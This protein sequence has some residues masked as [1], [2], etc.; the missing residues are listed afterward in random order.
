MCFD[1]LPAFMKYPQNPEEGIGF[2]GTRVIN[3]ADPPQGC[4]ASNPGSLEEQ[5]LKTLIFETSE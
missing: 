3:N 5:D 1:V 2:P 4:L